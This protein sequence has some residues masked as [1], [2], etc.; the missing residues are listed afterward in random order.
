MLS[1]SNQ[2]LRKAA[3]LQS[4][5]Q[6]PRQAQSDCSL[7]PYVSCGTVVNLMNK[8][9]SDGDW[10]AWPVEIEPQERL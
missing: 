6:R 3:T 8:A 10:S 7:P 2:K 5:A 4:L 1:F 9:N